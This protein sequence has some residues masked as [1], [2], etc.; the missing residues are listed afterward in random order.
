MFP[1][2]FEA[3]AK[4][5]RKK[6]VQRLDPAGVFQLPLAKPT[7][8][9]RPQP[10]VFPMRDILDLDT[11]PLDR[12]DSPQWRA[13]VERCKADLA[14]DGMFNLEGLMHPQTAQDAALALAPAFASDSFHHERDH[15]VYFLDDVPGLAPDH[16]VLKRFHTS[17]NT[18]CGDQVRASPMDRLY[19]WPEFAGFLAAVMDKPELYRMADELAGLNVIS[20]G[21]GQALNWHFDRS[22]FTTTMLLQAPDQGGE[23]V[24]CPD[25]RSNTDPNYDAVARMLQGDDDQVQTLTLSPG[26]LNVFRGVNS[27]HRV[28]PVIGPRARIIAVFCFYEHPDAS[29][30]ESERIGFFGR[31][32]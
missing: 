23:F 29:F 6:A 3:I 12:P 18:L 2:I 14:R 5:A 10:M 4:D 17:N 30:S 16:P 8:A 7:S 11:Y 1:T 32:S 9:L 25:M 28:I 24:Y 20:Y 19:R 21:E 15:N 31:A 27:P 22:E 26:T 13:L